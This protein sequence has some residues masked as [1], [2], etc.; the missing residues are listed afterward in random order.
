MGTHST[1]THSRR[2]AL[3][4]VAVA[5]VLAFGLTTVHA[6]GVPGVDSNK[7]LEGKTK[8]VE[9]KV[10]GLLK[11]REKCQKD[12][13]KCGTVQTDCEAKVREKF[14][15]VGTKLGCFEKLEAKDDGLTPDRI[16]T[17]TGDLPAMEERAD[18]VV[19]G[20]LFTL[21]GG[22][23]PPRFGDNGDGTVTDNQTGLMWEKKSDDG[24][25]SINDKDLTY[26][27][28]NADIVHV[29]ALNGGPFAGYTDWRLPTVSELQSIADYG[30]NNPAVPAEFNNG[31]AL[32]CTVLTCSCT[33]SSL[34]WSST[35]VFSNSG[36]AWYVDFSN[37]NV[38]F[39]SKTIAI[40]VRAVRTP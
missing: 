3:G 33:V 12:P 38:N 6:Q 15:G 5:V 26:N 24:V 35:T 37:G 16:C 19:T 13:L 18:D 9:K 10:A 30:T 17:T 2:A 34:Y 28:S 29:A 32:N 40:S 22:V 25:L 36:S 20:I 7:C 1:L 14:D 27:W 11:C 8:C 23:T 31:C 39:L 4:A 21:E